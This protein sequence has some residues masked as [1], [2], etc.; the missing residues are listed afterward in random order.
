MKPNLLQTTLA[1][2]TL[3]VGA[4][5]AMAQNEAPAKDTLQVTR[6]KGDDMS[7]AA[8]GGSLKTPD[9]NLQD[10]ALLEAL[11][12]LPGFN[13]R[14]YTRAIGDKNPG[15]FVLNGESP[16]LSPL[17]A[18]QAAQRVKQTV[19]YAPLTEI[20]PPY[21]P[22]DINDAKAWEGFKV[23]GPTEKV[24]AVFPGQPFIHF[25]Y[26]PHKDFDPPDNARLSQAHSGQV[27]TTVYAIPKS[28][29]PGQYTLVIPMRA[30]AASD[31]ELREYAV[32]TGNWT[33][34][35]ATKMESLA[36]NRLPTPDN[37]EMPGKISEVLKGEQDITL[38]QVSMNRL[39]QAD[40]L[41]V[42]ELPV[43][44]MM[45]RDAQ[46]VTLGEQSFIVANGIELTESTSVLCLTTRAAAAAATPAL[47]QVQPHDVETITFN[48]LQ[49]AVP[50]PMKANTQIYSGAP[51]HALLQQRL[52]NVAGR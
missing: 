6:V 12:K 28:S 45:V 32:V 23:F 4:S 33:M 19:A 5:Q 2:V 34:D 46:T 39:N 29:Q 22:A 25:V 1:S 21:S 17:N 52:Q 49:V 14:E 15:D 3:F 31:A 24:D 7:Q 38:D 36:G 41:P 11:G 20:L 27:G 44:P 43:R 8:I 42:S 16:A 35:I 40:R 13:A 37:P 30:E 10:A 18:D 9:L 50:A 48:V 51:N 26:G 47:Y